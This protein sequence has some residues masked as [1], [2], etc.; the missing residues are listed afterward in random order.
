MYSFTSAVV[1]SL[2]FKCLIHFEFIF[3]YDIK[4]A[5]GSFFCM[6]LSSFPNIIY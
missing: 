6:W 3:V 5:P 4:Q 2:I 1:L